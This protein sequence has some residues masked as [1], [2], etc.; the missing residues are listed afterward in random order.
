MCVYL[1]T[2]E[3]CTV[4]NITSKVENKVY[5]QAQDTCRYILSVSLN[6]CQERSMQITSPPPFDLTT[7]PPLQRLLR[8]RRTVIAT[9]LPS[10]RSRLGRLEIRRHIARP[11]AII[12]GL[13][14]PMPRLLVRLLRLRNLPVRA[15]LLDLL[16]VVEIGV[17]VLADA[18]SAL[19]PREVL[20]VH[21]DAVVLVFAT[22]ADKLPAALLLFEVEAGGVGQEEEGDEHA[23]QA[24]PGDD[25]EFRL[26]VNVIV[27]NG[28]EERAEFAP[29][30]AEAVRGG[31]DGRGVDFSGYEEGDGVGAELVEERGE[32]VHGLKGC[33]AREALVVLKVE[34][35]NDEKDKVHQEANHLHLLS[36]AAPKL[37]SAIWPRLTWTITY[38]NLLSMRKDAR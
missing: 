24:E 18:A 17:V 22:G 28:G 13:V 34:C 26:R 36:S 25:V 30:G 23:G 14:V 1:K 21:G 27:E 6:S 15:H 31:A 12:H 35:G 2:L 37:E 5:V 33:N 11:H 8:H 9:L 20:G 32:E 4:C 38:Y 29:G 3:V 7:I 10:H 19:P 16:R